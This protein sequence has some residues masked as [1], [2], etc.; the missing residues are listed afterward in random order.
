[1]TKVIRLSDGKI[2]S[3]PRGVAMNAELPIERAVY[4][5]CKGY[6]LEVH[7]EKYQWHYEEHEEPMRRQ[8]RETYW[9]RKGKW[10]SRAWVMLWR[11]KFIK[12]WL[13]RIDDPHR[14]RK[15]PEVAKGICEAAQALDETYKW[16][17]TSQ[18][19]SKHLRAYQEFYEQAFGMRMHDMHT[20]IYKGRMFKFLVKEG[21]DEFET[22]VKE[23]ANAQAIGG[24]IPV[25]RMND[26]MKFASMAEAE[27]VTRVPYYKIFHCCEGDIDYC[28]VPLTEERMV[29]RYAVRIDR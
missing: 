7:G 17:P 18:A 4:Y 19:L 16:E 6:L 2:F 28:E 23:L 5:C 26:N 3:G 9:Q 14:W 10:S 24:G 25:I 12:A 21:S 29:F 13:D 27:R 22:I 1:M 15:A 8:E 11:A 20:P